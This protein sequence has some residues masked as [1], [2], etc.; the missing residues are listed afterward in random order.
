MR[1][2]P[3]VV[4]P[5]GLFQSFAD[6]LKLFIKE[7]VVPSGAN[8]GIFILAPMLTFVLALIGWAVIPWDVGAVLADIN[9]G[10]LFIFAISSLGVYGIIMSGWASNSRYAF[11]G[12]LRSAAQM[13]SYE[14]SMGFVLVTLISYAGSTNLSAIVENQAGGLW[15]WHFIWFFPMFVIFLIS[16]MAETNRPPFDLPEAEAELVAGYQ[17]EYS[18]M[19][20]AL[21]WLGEYGNILLM[22][23]L[24]SVLFFG[25]WYAPIS[26]LDFIPGPL[27]MIGKICFFFFIFAWVK[28]TVPRYRYDQLMRL[29][30]K[31]FLPLSLAAVV[32]Y[33]GWGM[34]FGYIG[35]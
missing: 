16:A 30:W 5:F 14:V 24:T 20:F 6:G 23:A 31:V 22:C 9:V 28:A 35:N 10:I 8:K 34:A 29:G 7:T 18:S 32:F 4:G 13:V 25:G 3:N 12:G 1:R 2:G 26:A 15:Q 27:W 11:L 33:T 19:A 17:V 21:F